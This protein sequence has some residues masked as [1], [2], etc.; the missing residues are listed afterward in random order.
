MRPRKSIHGIAEKIELHFVDLAEREGFEPSKGVLS[1][2]TPLAGE[3]F[4]PLSHL[5]DR[6]IELRSGRADVILTTDRENRER[7][8]RTYWRAPFTS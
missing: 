5:S 6:E 2:L 8:L 3:R 1:A 7:Q 4:R